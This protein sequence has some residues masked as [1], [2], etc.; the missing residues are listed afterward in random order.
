[1]KELQEEL[2]E[3]VGWKEACIRIVEK[4]MVPIILFLFIWGVIKISESDGL[5]FKIIGAINAS[6]NAPSPGSK[7]LAIPWDGKNKSAIVSPIISDPLQACWFYYANYI[8]SHPYT[9][10]WEESMNAEGTEGGDKIR[11]IADPAY[12]YAHSCVKENNKVKLI[13]L[14]YTRHSIEAKLKKNEKDGFVHIAS[15]DA[16]YR[17]ELIFDEQGRIVERKV[18][19]ADDYDCKI[20]SSSREILSLL[21]S[22][23]VKD[24]RRKCD[25]EESIKDV[26][27]EEERRKKIENLKKQ[28]N[29]FNKLEIRPTKKFSKEHIDIIYFYVD[30]RNQ[31]HKNLTEKGCGVISVEPKPE[32]NPKEKT[33]EKAVSLIK[34]SIAFLCYKEGGG[35]HVRLMQRE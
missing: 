15:S 34:P 9:I 4:V 8:N 23:S 7:D 28:D 35:S 13:G 14:E 22:N 5:V 12:W 11:V 3:R 6:S 27:S 16:F 18:L 2:P 24:S 30:K 25:K 31:V 21:A 33:K 19:K 32:E 1:M 29:P 10:L 17:S 26:E 20:F